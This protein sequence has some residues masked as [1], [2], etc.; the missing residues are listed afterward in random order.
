VCCFNDDI[1][2][3]AAVGLAGVLAALRI[4]GGRLRDQRFLFLGAGSAA[5]GIADL[6]SKAMVQEGAALDEARGRSWLFDVHGLVESSRGDLTAFQG[7][8]AHAH[9]P[10]RDFAALVEDLQPT[11]IIGVSGV[12]R[13]FTREVVEAM[14]RVNERPIVFPLSNPTTHAECT[15]EEAYTWSGGRA[16]VA[17]GSP[18]GPVRVGDR[19][20][21]PAQGNNVHVFP[22]M[23]LAIYT[24][25]ATRVTDELFI[26][27]ARALADQVRPSD[28]ELGMVFPPLSSVLE[29]SEAVAT[30]VAA[31]I[32]ERGLARIDLPSDLAAH[33][34]A[35]TYQ[36][37]Y[38][39]LS[40]G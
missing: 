35:H 14:A 6:L 18:F 36:P 31:L 12:G 32:V 24:T 34:A 11:A 25:Q 7:P 8:F 21:V 20:L 9:S 39:H 40:G 37:D 4:T 38:A 3:T 2:G 26:E 17:T 19:T 10:S 33:I 22:A 5:V 28:L 1:Q 30:R 15:A 27:A 29:T 23:G 13:T 16:V